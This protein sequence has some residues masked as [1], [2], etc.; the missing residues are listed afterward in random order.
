MDIQI[1]L[2]LF[3][4]LA[5]RMP[6]HPDRFAVSPGAT[7]GDVLSVLGISED[8]AKLIFIN[9]RRAELTTK[10]KDGDRLGVFPPV[11]GG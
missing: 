1:S 9:N 6:E 5:Q 8:D 10:L 3:A 4:T 7:A 2:R 11:G